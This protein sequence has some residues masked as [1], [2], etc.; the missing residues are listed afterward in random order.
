MKNE[1]LEWNETV[2]LSVLGQDY[3]EKIVFDLNRI[4]GGL[5]MTIKFI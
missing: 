5:I 1:Y 4:F 3:A 2:N